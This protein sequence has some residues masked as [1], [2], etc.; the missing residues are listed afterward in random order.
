MTLV[1]AISEGIIAIGSFWSLQNLKDLIYIIV[2]GVTIYVALA[3]FNKWKKEL[4]GKAYFD[5]SHRFLKQ[6]YIIRDTLNDARSTLFTPPEL[7]EVGPPS[8]DEKLAELEHLYT[9]YSNRHKNVLAEA[10]EFNSLIAEGEALHGKSFRNLAQQMTNK[11]NDYSYNIDQHLQHKRNFIFGSQRSPTPEIW[12][13][14][15]HPVIH[16]LGG[17]G[18]DPFGDSI[19]KIVRDLDKVLVPY[20]R[21][22]RP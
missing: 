2:A 17:K 12:K 5:F 16:R 8:E 10:Q 4:R 20:I 6:A 11:L 21:K 14:E 19:D 1:Q 15:V 9:V 7:R 22:Y 3:G 13:K 18:K